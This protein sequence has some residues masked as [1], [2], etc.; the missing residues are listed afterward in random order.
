MSTYI[1]HR[2]VEYGAEPWCDKCGQPRLCHLFEV[3]L[4][5]PMLDKFEV[6]HPAGEIVEVGGDCAIKLGVNPY[7]VQKADRE[8]SKQATANKQAA[9]Q[10]AL[11]QAKEAELAE[12][13]SLF[14]SR[15]KIAK[16]KGKVARISNVFREKKI[17]IRWV[18]GKWLSLEV[19]LPDGWTTDLPGAPIFPEYDPVKQWVEDYLRKQSIDEF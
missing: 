13:M 1:G 18:G 17:S 3:L 6:L 14:T 8:M 19:K 10:L 16:K 2:L 12:E 9:E 5:E 15:W 4:D 11:R 7:T